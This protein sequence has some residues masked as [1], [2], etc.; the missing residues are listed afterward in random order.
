MFSDAYITIENAEAIEL[1]EKVN[2]KLDGSHFDPNYSR[3]ISHALPF[4][5]GYH[6]G[7]ITDLNSSPMRQISFIYEENSNKEDIYIL[8]GTNE[9][10][11]LL[12]KKVPIFLNKENI[13][14][15]VRFF[16]YYVRGR[17]GRFNIVEN[18]DEINWREEP[19]PSGRRAL[20]KMIQ[21]LEFKETAKEDY[22][23]SCSIIFKDSLFES[24]ITVQENGDVSLS[25]QEMLVED[26]PVLDDSFQQ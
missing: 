17:F 19:A 5:N 18:V 1:A 25:N 11:Y 8:D 15:Y 2:A 13:I 12:N 24:D 26:I 9:P 16:F 7:E 20:G 4:Y 10:I 23:L 14:T 22:Q 6:L 3:I 21:P